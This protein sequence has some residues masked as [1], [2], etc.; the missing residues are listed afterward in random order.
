VSDAEL[1]FVLV[2][3]AILIC[4]KVLSTVRRRR[5]A[6]IECECGFDAIDTRK[7]ASKDT[8]R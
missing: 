6:K 2:V 4:V 1:L 8:P 5:Q 3:A 7:A